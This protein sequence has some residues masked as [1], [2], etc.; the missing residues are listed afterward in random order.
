MNFKRNENLI[1]AN[2]RAGQWGGAGGGGPFHS[3]SG[4]CGLLSSAGRCCGS[5]C[6]RR[7]A[8]FCTSNAASSGLEVDLA[9][10]SSEAA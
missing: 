6:D 5:I 8:A 4:G 7:S 1:G 10:L 3:T 9:N 2:K